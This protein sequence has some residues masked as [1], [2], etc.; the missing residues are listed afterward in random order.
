MHGQP[1]YQLSSVA[2]QQAAARNLSCDERMDAGIIH[3]AGERCS[4]AEH[5]AL[6]IPPLELY[7]GAAALQLPLSHDGN[8][9]N[10]CRGRRQ[11]EKYLLG[12]ARAVGGQ[13]SMHVRKGTCLRQ[14]SSFPSAMTE[15]VYW[16][17][18]QVG[19]AGRGE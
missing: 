15:F 12:K 7:G 3:G 5:I 8:L 10:S 18:K 16:K 6:A 1:V 2:P 19:C 9:H 4:Q 11:V 14:I 13:C 17:R